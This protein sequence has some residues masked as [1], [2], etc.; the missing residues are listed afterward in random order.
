MEALQRREGS[1]DERNDCE[2]YERR[3][4]EADQ[5]ER[6]TNRKLTR[7]CFGV[8]AALG[9]SF[10]SQTIENRRER[11]AVSVA[12]RERVCQGLGDAAKSTR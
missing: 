3:Q 5:R 7:R 10:V 9:A 6:E 1:G 4:G 8:A 12:Q 2:Q 11:S